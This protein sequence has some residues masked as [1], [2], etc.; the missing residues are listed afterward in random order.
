MNGKLIGV[1]N[2]GVN[3]SSITIDGHYAYV[4]NSNNYEIEGQDSVI[5]IDLHTNLPI[6]TI[7]DQ[8]FKEPYRI[9]INKSK[10]YVSNSSSS[11]ISIINTR[12]NTVTRIINGFDGPSGFV[13]KDKLGYVNNYGATPGVGSGNGNTVSMVDLITEK[14]IGSP[15]IVGLAPAAIVSD[16]NY[17]Y[18]VNYVDGNPHTGTI[19]KICTKC[20]KVVDTII[21]FSGPFDMKIKDKKG[22][23]TNFGS[24]NF[25][26]FGTTV[27]VVDLKNN[28]IIN[29]I[30]VG[31]QPAGIAIHDKYVYV[32]NYNTLYAHANFQNLTF[33][34]GTINVIDLDTNKV[35]STIAVGNS[36]NYL[37]V[38]DEYLYIVNYTQNCISIVKV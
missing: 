38:N 35:V 29:N 16:K 6:T 13:I 22:Y 9:T 20:N 27:S 7:F 25:A 14:I 3:P 15:I 2:T 31:I 21:G 8:S 1:I 5:V 37:V 10:A 32:S 18:T 24:N 30:T 28:I 23:V 19:S 4:T 17:I 12:T 34:Q 36:P 26:P 33:G 11:T